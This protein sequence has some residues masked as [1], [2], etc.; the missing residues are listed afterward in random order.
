MRGNSRRVVRQVEELDDLVVDGLG[1]AAK[2]SYRITFTCFGGR[3][4]KRRFGLGPETAD[5]RILPARNDRGTPWQ[6]QPLA[7]S[8][9]SRQA[10][11]K[12]LTVSSET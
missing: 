10:D 12:I 9:W 11:F 5:L 4:D 2:S 6:V 3:S 1:D 8:P 7:A